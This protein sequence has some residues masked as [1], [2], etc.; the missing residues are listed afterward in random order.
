MA[1]LDEFYIIISY[2]L[3]L[4]KFH[5]FCGIYSLS[6]NPKQENMYLIML[7][8]QNLILGKSQNNQ[9]VIRFRFH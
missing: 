6:N 4:T 2:E 3:S 7:I 9:I 1:Q 8:F 5:F